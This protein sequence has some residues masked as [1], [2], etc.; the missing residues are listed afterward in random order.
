EVTA[1][2][3]DGWEVRPPAGPGAPALLSVR[4]RE[5]L[6]SGSLAVRCFAPLGSG[7]SPRWTAPSVRLLDAAP[8]GETL[9]LHLDPD[10][11]LDAWQPGG[12]RL[13]ESKGDADGQTL[14]LVGGLIDEGGEG[15]PAARPTA[16]VRARG[17]DFRARELALWKVDPERVSLLA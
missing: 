12:F 5:P 17:T 9:L 8:G 2:D 10:V 3:L 4:L 11:S 16:R 6:L 13:V 14:R 15:K 7:D 1:P